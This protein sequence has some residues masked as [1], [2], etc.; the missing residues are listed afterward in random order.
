MN[1]S[2]KNVNYSEL[3]ALYWIWKNRLNVFGNSYYGLSHYRRILEL[4]EDDLLRLESNNV[5]VVLPYPMP[6]E[7]NIEEHHKRYLAEV[8][9]EALLAALKEL[10]PEYA[11]AFPSILH[12]AIFL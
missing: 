11:K 12:L 9:W 8:D 3:T 5:D 2:V 1:I 6:Y 7:P 10:Q 4:S